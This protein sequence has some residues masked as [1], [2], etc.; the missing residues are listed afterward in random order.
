VA[1]GWVTNQIGIKM[2]FEPAAPRKLGPF[3]LQGLFVRRQHEASKAYAN[4]VAEDIVTLRNI[5]DELLHGSRA[6]RT[7]QMI[8]RSLRE[9]V[10]G[11]VGP[12]RPAVR[13][14][15]GPSE[16]ERMRESVAEAGIEGT[17]A[18]LQDPGFNREQ[19]KQL[20]DLLTIR[21]RELSP[22]EFAETLRTAM[23]EDEW[24]LYLHG[25]VLGIFS[26]CL[27]LL[28]FPP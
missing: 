28:A 16:Y 12:A 19:K 20:R 18:P 25:G 15:A 4:V 14:A 21:L 6:D 9:A 11:A 26:G 13:M 22:G 24:L 23:R 27:H 1:I 8:R 17:M 5:G 7:R 10:D 2:I 3:T